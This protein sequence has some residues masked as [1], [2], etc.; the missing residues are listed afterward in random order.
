MALHELLGAGQLADPQGPVNRSTVS[1]MLL[2]A[3]FFLFAHGRSSVGLTIRTQS[4]EA[5][6]SATHLAPTS[7]KCP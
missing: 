4:L 5:I 6:L 2:G 7:V 3:H 1:A